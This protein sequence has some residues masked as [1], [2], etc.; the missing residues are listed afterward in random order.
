VLAV[1]NHLDYASLSPWKIV[2]SLADKGQYIASESTFYR[3]LKAEKCL[4]HREKSMRP[5]FIKNLMN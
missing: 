5:E 3:I 1:A 4:Q 2:A